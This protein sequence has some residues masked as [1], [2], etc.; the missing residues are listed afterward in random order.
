M[1]DAPRDLELYP[2]LW[3]GIGLVRGGAGTALVGSHAEVADRIAAVTV[4]EV[5]AH[6][7]ALIGQ[8]RPALALYGPV[9]AAP[10]RDALAERLA[11]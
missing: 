5:R 7:E 1:P 8:A 6:A 9:K 2:N 11:A 10:A 3:S 4:A